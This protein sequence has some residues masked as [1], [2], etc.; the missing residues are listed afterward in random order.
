MTLPRKYDRDRGL[1]ARPRKTWPCDCRVFFVLSFSSLLA[2]HPAWELGCLP[3][4]TW[5]VS[6]APRRSSVCC[7]FTGITTASVNLL[8]S[9]LLSPLKK[10][11]NPTSPFKASYQAE[12]P[13]TNIAINYIIYRLRRKKYKYIPSNCS[14]Y[15]FSF[16]FSYLFG[17]G[18]KNSQHVSVRADYLWLRQSLGNIVLVKWYHVQTT[19]Y[20]KW[21]RHG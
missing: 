14:I 18:M 11:T 13:N 8:L 4:H 7:T 10:E 1:K 20:K 3:K 15:T 17:F 9:F 5:R 16:Y 19:L 2:V 12:T 21:K 6:H